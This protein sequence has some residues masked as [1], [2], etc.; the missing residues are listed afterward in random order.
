MKYVRGH[1]NDFNE[2]ASLGAD[3]WSY[4]EVLPYFKKSQRFH[5]GQGFNPEYQS[6]TGQLGV[7]TLPDVS[8]EGSKI[9]EASLADLSGLKQGDYNGEEQ[10]V[11]YRSQFS[12]NS[13]HRADAYTSFAAPFVGKGV[14]VLTH[15][16][17]T[18]ISFDG[19]TARSVKVDRFGEELEYFASKEV[20]VS[21][22]T[23][24]SP[25]LLMLSGIGPK[26]HLKEVGIENVILD[27]PGVG[28]N[29]QDHLMTVFEISTNG[30]QP[31]K[32]GLDPLFAVKPWN[33]WTF[34]TQRLFQGPMADSG[35]GS[36]AFLH[37]PIKGNDTWK[38][39]DIQMHTLPVL[40]LA[41]YGALYVQ[42]LGLSDEHLK[43]YGDHIGEDGVTLLPTLLRPKSRGEITLASTNPHD[44]PVIDPHYLE[45]A[46]DVKTLV[47]SLKICKDL[48][49]SR[50]FKKAGMSHFKSPHCSSHE[51]WSDDY[52]ECVVKHVSLTVYHP[53]GTCKMG[54]VNDPLAVVD[55]KL[56][57]IGLNKIRIIDASVMPK[58]VGGNTNAAAIMIGEKGSDMILKEYGRGDAKNEPSKDEL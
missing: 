26:E 3:G 40:V 4:D 35:I 24:G 12:Q 16:H 14:T 19:K 38:R 51:L 37:T 47:E 27:R 57:L 15:A 25:Q 58:I 20:I 10:N 56:R 49:E 54:R 34:Y 52:Y 9:I 29:L 22:G 46:E 8:C 41:D 36:G 53:V 21:A 5:D 32:I 50:H 6:D 55:P 45:E 17:A 18:K 23:I 1:K 44:S 2:W 11:W 48:S 13:G 31:H 43:L 30:N 28:K 42:N 7:R 39:P 33:Y